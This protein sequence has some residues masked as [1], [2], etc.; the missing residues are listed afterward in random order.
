MAKNIRVG[1][2]I[3][4]ESAHRDEYLRGLAETEEVQS[5]ALADATGKM[6]DRAR[7]LLGTKLDGGIFKDVGQMLT[8]A[9]PQMALITLPAVDA[10][11]A[12]DAALEAGCHVLAEKPACIRAEDFAPLVTKA[13]RKHRELMLALGNR[14]HPPVR[15]ARKLI[16]DGILG[17]LYGVNL[18]LIA[19]QTRLKNPAYHKQ[20]FASRARAGGGHLIWLGIHWLDLV[21]HFTGQSTKQVAALTANVGGQPIDVEDSAVVALRFDGG[22]QGTLQSGYYLDRGY[23]SHLILWGEHGWLRLALSD[24]HALEWY[25]NRGQDMP[26]VKRI[27]YPRQA[28]GYTPLVRAAVRAAAGLEPAPV[29]GAEGLLVLKAIFAAYRA[30]ATGTTQTVS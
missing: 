22:M 28:G 9:A 5:V 3:E 20:W 23:H 8:R 27:E 18:Y 24:N 26:V 19:D 25:S 1:L 4:P 30:A 11:P 12:I 13:Q 6:A 29:T 14:L 16:R 21:H 10:P 7:E 2:V 17:K 15:E